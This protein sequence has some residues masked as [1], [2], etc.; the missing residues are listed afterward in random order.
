MLTVSV[1]NINLYYLAIFLQ[2]CIQP[3]HLLHYLTIVKSVLGISRGFCF[4]IYTELQLIFGFS[5]A[6]LHKTGR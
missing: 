5:T 4:N 2:R 1:E 6:D 3:N